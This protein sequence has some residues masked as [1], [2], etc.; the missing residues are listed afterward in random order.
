MMN[1]IDRE[2]LLMGQKSREIILDKF[3]VRKVNEVILD[4]IFIND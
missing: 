3:D 2:T 4:Q 1:L